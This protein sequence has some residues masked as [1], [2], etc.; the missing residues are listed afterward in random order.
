MTRSTVHVSSIVVLRLA[1]EISGCKH[2]VRGHLPPFISRLR[3]RTVEFSPFIAFLLSV[4]LGIQLIYLYLRFLRLGTDI[5][6]RVLEGMKFEIGIEI[7]LGQ[8]S[9]PHS[10]HHFLFYRLSNTFIF[11]PAMI[12]FPVMVFLTGLRRKGFKRRAYVHNDRAETD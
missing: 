11:F 12:P 3:R 1:I 7:N 5:Y 10:M 9:R 4:G 2:C 8:S 6:P